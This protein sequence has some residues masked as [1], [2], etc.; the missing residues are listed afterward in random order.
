MTSDPEIVLFM[1]KVGAQG[2][3]V[4]N[5]LKSAG[6]ATDNVAV[7]VADCDEE[8]RSMVDASTDSLASVLRGE[9][10]YGTYQREEGVMDLIV[11]YQ[12]GEL[13]KG[14]TTGEG[15]YCYNIW[16]AGS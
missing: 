6:K 2:I 8:G 13:E 14:Y 16:L 15:I 12:E 9:I 4:N 7:F 11:R 3:G 5:Y 10:G 1:T